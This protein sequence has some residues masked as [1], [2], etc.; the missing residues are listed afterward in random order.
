[1]GERLGFALRLARE[2]KAEVTKKEDKKDMKNIWM[3][4]LVIGVTAGLLG[5]GTYAYFS[6]PESASNT[7]SAGTLDLQLSDDGVTYV[8]DPIDPLI[9]CL[10]MAPGDESV[11]KTLYFK[12]A[13]TMSGIV[14]VNISYVEHDDPLDDD[15]LYNYEYAVV[16]GGQE[17]SADDFAKHLWV[18]EASL[19]GGPN[20]VS[21]WALQVVDDAYAGNWGNALADFA[22]YDPDG[23]VGVPDGNE[24]PTAYG[25]AQIT[26]HFWTSYHGTDI[27][28]APGDVHYETL[29]AKLDPSVNNDYQFDGIYLIIEPTITQ[30][31]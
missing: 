18:T 19:D 13:G 9:E 15:S 31:H 1:V 4:I 8:N 24:L 16:N 14:I 25:L 22:V 10:N 26:L 2:I 12:N 29:K 20:I 5:T 23:G 21:Y 27:P 11:E 28:F 3:S 17:V 6:D 30:V 7:F